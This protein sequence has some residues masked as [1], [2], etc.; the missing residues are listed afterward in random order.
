MN[1]RAKMIPHP[2]FELIKLEEKKVHNPPVMQTMSSCT[3]EKEGKEAG[4]TFRTMVSDEDSYC[5]FSV[6]MCQRMSMA[7]EIEG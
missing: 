4:Q 3:C 6:G 5:P 1:Q 2:V 7:K